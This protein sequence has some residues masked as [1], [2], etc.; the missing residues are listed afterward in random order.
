M[1]VLRN[2]F[3]LLEMLIAVIILVIVSS[4]VVGVFRNTLENYKKGMSYSEITEGISGV[5]M[6]MKND[7]S[8]MRP[9]GDK[10]SVFFK[11]DELSFVCISETK[12]KKSFL[13]LIRYKFDHDTLTRGSVKYPE[14]IDKISQDM[15]P[16]LNGVKDF[17]FS[18][19]FEKEESKKKETDKQKSSA[20]TNNNSNETTKENKIKNTAENDK[21]K[22]V[23]LPK[24]VNLTATIENKKI[25]EH[26][27][28]AL[29]ATF[30]N[31]S[32][33]TG[34]GSDSDKKDDKSSDSSNELQN[35]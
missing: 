3:T 15:F 24:I 30:I 23:K 27:S 14:D 28:T 18:Y 25:E 31:S 13:E 17:N 12:D 33:G 26:F 8:R 35:R 19:I 9:I 22:K 11:V 20:D 34:I 32:P 7:L 10:K 16:F 2:N 1:K 4:V 21:K 29:Y 6:I 5:Y